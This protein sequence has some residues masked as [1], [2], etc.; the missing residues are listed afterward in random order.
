MTRKEISLSNLCRNQLHDVAV[1]VPETQHR[2]VFG[3]DDHSPE[4]RKAVSHCRTLERFDTN[5]ETS[6]ARLR[7][8]VGIARLFKQ[9]AR[10]V[11]EFE[12]RAFRVSLHFIAVE[13]AVVRQ[14][15]I[16]VRH[17]QQYVVDA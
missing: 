2:T 4:F 8:P 6:N 7:R 15:A 13:D 11:A 3:I 1:R 12:Y 17:M 5:A 16:D 9:Q 14:R 10:A